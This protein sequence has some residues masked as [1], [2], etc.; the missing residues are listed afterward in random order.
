VPELP[1]HFHWLEP[2]RLAGL[3][4]PGLGRDVEHDLAALAGAGIRLLVSLTEDPFPTS[5]LRPL[6]IVGRHL[7]IA[8]MSVPTIGGC[9]SVC[10]DIARHLDAGEGVAVHCHAGMGRTGT[11]LAAF[12]VWNGSAPESAIDRVRA[13]ARGYIQNRSQEEFI[14]RFAESIGPRR[15]Q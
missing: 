8:D 9:A 2:H 10:R 5:L 4:R 14:R 3:G 6:A 7:P 15:V 1:R 11:V 13:V 12:L